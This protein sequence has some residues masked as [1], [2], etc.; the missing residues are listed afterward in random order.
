MRSATGDTI[1]IT[2][3]AI[4]VH[5]AGLRD[6]VSSA[7]HNGGS[8]KD[9]TH[10]Y[11][12]TYAHSP[13]VQNKVVCK[14]ESPNLQSHYARLTQ[15]LG[16]PVETT[17][18]MGTAALLEDAALCTSSFENIHLSTI[19]T[20]GVDHN[21]GRAGDPPSYDEFTG[22]NLPPSGTIN[23]ML[24]I[25]AHL[26]AGT[27]VQAIITATEAKSAA[28]Q[29]LQAGSLYSSGIATGSGTDTI[30]VV[31]RP[32]ASD[33]LYDAGHHSR[34]GS[35][36][37]QLVKQAVKQALGH[38]DNGMTPSRQA[39]LLWQGFRHGITLASLS[40]ESQRLYGD[41]PGHLQV[42]QILKDPQILAYCAPLLHLRDQYDWGILNEKQFATVYRQYLHH[43]CQA[44]QLPI[45]DNLISALAHL[46]HR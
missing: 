34:L 4:I 8:R 7:A 43:F 42:E 18:G 24:F 25:D 14:M 27:A 28:L 39:S 16:L 38:H 30:M 26:P 13:L 19:V 20:A 32:D 1:S 36:I 46:N 15:E 21:G 9:L 23:I 2:H 22:E 31:T 40:S 6:V 44:Y 5:L 11:N 35:T 33:T 37:G 10:L 3:Q 41:L 12:Y 45:T 17:A 29:E